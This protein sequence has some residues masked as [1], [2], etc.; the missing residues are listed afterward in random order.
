MEIW[1][2]EVIRESPY[3]N[4]V[5]F[6]IVVYGHKVEFIVEIIFIVICCVVTDSSTVAIGML[7]SLLVM[8]NEG[9]Q[10]SLICPYTALY[11]YRVPVQSSNI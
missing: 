6:R 8:E 2:D 1:W 3:T 11:I 7:I 5:D 10:V 4:V 9:P